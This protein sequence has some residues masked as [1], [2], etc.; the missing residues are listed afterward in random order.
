VKWAQSVAI[1]EVSQYQSYIRFSIFLI[2]ILIVISRLPNLIILILTIVIVAESIS[3]PTT[4]ALP[5]P[6]GLWE[7]IVID[8]K[9]R[10]SPLNV[11]K[12]KIEVVVAANCFK[13]I[14]HSFV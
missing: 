14:N 11:S 6:P 1:R 8:S 3:A 10:N 5:G 2:L 4:I 12:V 7:I 9:T 13:A